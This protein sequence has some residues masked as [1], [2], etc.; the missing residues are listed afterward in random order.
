MK[1]FG[2]LA[3]SY[4]ATYIS[5]VEAAKTRK[6]VV[7]DPLIANAVDGKAKVI[8]NSDVTC[9]A[10]CGGPYS[11][12]SGFSASGTNYTEW[13]YDDKL[14]SPRESHVC[15]GDKAG[16]PNV[17]WQKTCATV[18]QKNEYM[19]PEQYTMHTTGEVEVHC[20][21]A[22]ADA[23]VPEAYLPKD[24]DGKDKD[25]CE[26]GL[27]YTIARVTANSKRRED[28][29][30][31]R[32]TAYP[33]TAEA[34]QAACVLP[35]PTAPTAPPPTEAPTAPATA[36]VGTD[37]AASIAEKEIIEALAPG[38][39][40]SDASQFAGGVALVALICMLRLL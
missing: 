13:D 16:A 31:A 30:L 27:V 35:T 2:I 23:C 10:N 4:L 7:Y 5:G 20:F 32:C 12:G 36:F 1:V 37:C 33:K 34:A 24:A 28:A 39:S 25:E 17:E 38:P 15:T 21:S 3:V 18:V 8:P 40:D 14:E 11:L 29:S 26:Q 6:S 19:T 9:H 22:A